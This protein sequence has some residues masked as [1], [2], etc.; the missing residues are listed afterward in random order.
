MQY[1]PSKIIP[2][3]NYIRYINNEGLTLRFGSLIKNTFINKVTN[4]HVT[5][6][7][8]HFKEGQRSDVHMVSFKTFSLKNISDLTF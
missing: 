3:V 8:N 2:N 7:S 5:Y 6:N 4:R 1:K